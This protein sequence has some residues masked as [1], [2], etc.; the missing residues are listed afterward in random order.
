MTS[1]KLEFTL[2]AVFTIGPRDEKEAL[3]KYARLLANT[4]SI[5]NMNELVTGM[6]HIFLKILTLYFF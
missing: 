2:P 3:I 5:D 1:E 6:F 4:A